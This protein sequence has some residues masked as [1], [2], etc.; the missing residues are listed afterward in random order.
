MN[1]LQWTEPGSIGWGKRVPKPRLLILDPNP[2]FADILGESLK[3][4]GQYQ[5]SAVSGGEMAVQ[6][7]RQDGCDLAIMDVALLDVSPTELIARLRE[8]DP[9]TH[10]VL[11]PPFGEELA[12][13]LA[14]LDI[15]GTLHK[16]FFTRQLD[17]QIKSFLA[18]KV[19]TAPPTR[20]ERLRARL[21]EIEPLLGDLHNEVSADVVALVCQGELLAS[22]GRMSQEHGQ[23][24][25]QLIQENLETS[26]RLAAF[27]G[28]ADGQFQLYSFVG[29]TLSLY[30]LT[31][32]DLSLIAIPGNGI[33]PGVVHLRIKQVVEGL[34][35]L[36]RDDQ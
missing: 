26:N 17:G 19:R 7:A 32:D 24:L 27:L 22:S 1:V 5:V 8:L 20:V 15:Q 31:F 2:D 33:P 29:K 11:I 13:D 12:A 23:A 16:P 14:A 36:L 30:I 6:A 28:E 34:S 35:A 9:Y 25:F 18:Q 10:V 4:T 3:R 21:A